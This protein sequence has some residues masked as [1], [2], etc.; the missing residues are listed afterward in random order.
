MVYSLNRIH[1]TLTGMALATGLKITVTRA[2]P[3][4]SADPLRSN[5]R[6]LAAAECNSKNCGSVVI[7]CPEDPCSLGAEWI[8]HGGSMD[9]DR[10]YL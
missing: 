5:K 6:S 8:E 3:A 7:R 9:L 1:R 10:F 2:R 4:A